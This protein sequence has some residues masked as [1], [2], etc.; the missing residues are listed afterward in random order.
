MGRRGR[1]NNGLE[2]KIGKS[3]VSSMLFSF[4][5]HFSMPFVVESAGDYGQK[6]CKIHTHKDGPW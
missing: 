2:M 6:L 3:F 4:A 5:F 1:S